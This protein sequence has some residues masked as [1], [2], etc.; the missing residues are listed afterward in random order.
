MTSK[1]KNTNIYVEVESTVHNEDVLKGWMTSTKSRRKT[2]C[3]AGCKND[4]YCCAMVR[5]TDGRSKGKRG[6]IPVC[7]DHAL[8]SGEFP[9]AK[10]AGIVF[11][12]ENKEKIKVMKKKTNPSSSS[13]SKKRPKKKDLYDIFSF[14]Y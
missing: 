8:D 14:G 6:F 3:I 2:C 9:V 4:I 1:N 13:K 12:D 10:Q 7:I 11:L 5:V